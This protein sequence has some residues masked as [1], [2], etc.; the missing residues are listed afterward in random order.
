M[1]NKWI[2]LKT[3][4]GESIVS[5][6]VEEIPQGPYILVEQGKERDFV[7]YFYTMNHTFVQE[8][9]M[10]YGYATYAI[11]LATGLPIKVAYIYDTSD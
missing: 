4:F 3:K 8:F 10:K 5:C 6:R 11:N 9:T 7:K 1:G 2:E